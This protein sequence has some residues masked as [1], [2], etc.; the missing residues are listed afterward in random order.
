MQIHEQRLEPVEVVG[1]HQPVGD[2]RGARS[3]ARRVE[4]QD[5]FVPRRSRRHL[6][7]RRASSPTSRR[8]SPSRSNG[9]ATPARRV[10]APVEQRL[11]GAPQS[12]DRPVLVDV[13]CRSSAARDGAAIGARP[14]RARAAGP[15]ARRRRRRRRGAMPGRRSAPGKLRVDARLD[16]PLAQQVG[17]ESVNRADA[18]LL[19]VAQ[20][21]LEPIALGRRSFATGAPPRAPRAGAASARP[22][23]SR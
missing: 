14:R 17:A 8:I 20:R 11:A 22:R 4:V 19:Q 5:V 3:R 6:R 12:L 7:K 9:S 2:R 21:L 10:I 23:P 16:R 18:R 15:A 1:G 13:R